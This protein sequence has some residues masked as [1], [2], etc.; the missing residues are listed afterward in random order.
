MSNVFFKKNDKIFQNI[1]LDIADIQKR[2][3]IVDC[4]LDSPTKLRFYEMGLTPRTTVTITKRAPLG[5]PLEI[6]VIG[7]S[8]C[9][10]AQQAK[11]FTVKELL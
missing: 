5:D 3:V 9:L 1:S 7:Y 10:R 11:A 8:L 2:Y 6:R 4:Q